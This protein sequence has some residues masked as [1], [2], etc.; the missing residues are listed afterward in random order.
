[1][2]G[3]SLD[4]DDWAALRALA[5]R[6]LDG[7]LDALAGIREGVPWQAIPAEVRA[8]IAGDPL[9]RAASDPADV[10]AAFAEQIA[11]W[12]QPKNRG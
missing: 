5:H 8:A 3:G 9:P 6:A 1:V 11:P 4:P 12:T 2:N 7:S 10:Y